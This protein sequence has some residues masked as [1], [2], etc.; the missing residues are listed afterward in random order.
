MSSLRGK[1]IIVTGSSQGIGKTVASILLDK[2]ARVVLNGRNPEKL[3][4]AL[5]ELRSKG[6][7]IACSGDMARTEDCKRLRDQAIETFGQIDYLINNAGLASKGLVGDTKPEV[8]QSIVD[9][10][11]MGSMNPTMACMGD[12]KQSKGGILFISS[13]AGMMGLPSYSAYS[14][15]KRA[16]ISLAESLKIELKDSG[17]FVGVNF[18]G[19]TENDPKKEMLQ[20]DGS[21]ATMTKRDGVNPTPLSQT[22]GVIVKQ[23]EHRRFRM[24]SDFKGKALYFFSRFFPR[25]LRLIITRNRKKIIEMQ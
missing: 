16:I 10:N 1:V 13:L 7:V 23:L 21:A 24:Y 18:P 12:I 5:E 25:I 14:A 20:P 9:V 8:F 6:Q 22:A 3:N 4:T 19:F 2:G 17:V 15:T 11:I